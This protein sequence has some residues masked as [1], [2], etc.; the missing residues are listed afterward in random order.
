MILFWR[1][2]QPNQ[3]RSSDS[4]PISHRTRRSSSLKVKWRWRIFEKLKRSHFDGECVFGWFPTGFVEVE[5]LPLLAF[6][7]I[8]N[9]WQNKEIS[10]RQSCLLRLKSTIGHRSTKSVVPSKVKCQY[11]EILRD[12]IGKC[13]IDS[14][15]FEVSLL[16]GNKG[17]KVDVLYFLS[18]TDVFLYEVWL[19]ISDYRR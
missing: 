15:R 13:F 5:L 4:S 2:L 11:F 9:K 16:V 14:N 1:H 10:L 17:P 18:S 6:A 19:V 8:W 3:G 12:E 7:T